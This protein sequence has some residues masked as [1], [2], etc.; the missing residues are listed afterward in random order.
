MFLIFL[1]KTKKIVKKMFKINLRLI[2]EKKQCL[3][4][5]DIIQ[6]NRKKAKINS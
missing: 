3:I 6:K 2:L 5:T 1:F 4:K